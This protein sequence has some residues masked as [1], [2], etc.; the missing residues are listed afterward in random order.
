MEGNE[1]LI[2]AFVGMPG[3]GKSEASAYLR[4]KGLPIVRFGDLTDEG[5]SE[6]QLPVNPQN[7]AMFREKIRQELGMAAYAIKAKPKIDELLE[8]NPL[9]ILDGVYS[10][11]EYVYL[12]KT[13][14][15]LK[16]IHIF[17]QPV[18]RYKRLS[19]RKVRPFSPQDARKRD[20]AE[21]ENLHKAGPIAIADYLIENTGDLPTL[22]KKIDELLI[23]LQK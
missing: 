20:I 21:I 8:S 18:V 22:H 12:L 6:M 17:A 2:L 11:E 15:N 13:Y 9:I 1:H 4:T 23:A 3:A 16:I 7:E 19:V 10:W 5:L 14:E